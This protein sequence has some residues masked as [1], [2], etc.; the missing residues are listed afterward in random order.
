MT[1]A[2]RL[3]EQATEARLMATAA[4]RS[5]RD[6]DEVASKLERASRW[7]SPRHPSPTRHGRTC[8]PFW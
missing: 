7:A 2:Q 5:A 8:G 6:L 3:R 4:L 1:M